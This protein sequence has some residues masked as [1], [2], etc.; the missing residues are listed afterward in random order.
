MLVA[1]YYLLANR[2]SATAAA[3]TASDIHA[4]EPDG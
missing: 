1:G 4:D 3:A 2:T